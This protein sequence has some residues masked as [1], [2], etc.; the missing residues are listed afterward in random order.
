MGV[1]PEGGQPYGTPA[2]A[3]ASSSQPSRA[4]SSSRRPWRGYPDGP[5]SLAYA[6]SLY[7]PWQCV[8]AVV[9]TTK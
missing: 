9:P 3:S 5:P 2:T 7:G 1:Q 8:S 6:K 4:S